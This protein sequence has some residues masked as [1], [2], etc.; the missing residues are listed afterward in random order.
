MIVPMKKVYI[1]VQEKD[2]CAAMKDLRSL[3]AVHI[4]HQALPQGADINSIKDDITLLERVIVILSAPELAGASGLR[5]LKHITEWRFTAKHIIDTSARI[6]HLGEYS[7]TL[8]SRIVEWQPWGDF[9]PASIAALE[10]K[11]I[12]VKLYQI[13][14]KELPSLGEGLIVKRVADSKGVSY[15]AV[16]SRDPVTLPY[17]EAVPPAMGLDEMRMRLTENDDIMRSL[18]DTVRKS[19]CYLD[20][21]CA[22]RG[23]F[24]RELEFHEA[25]RGMGHAG[26][27]SSLAGYIP[28]DA[29]GAL[30]EAAGRHQWALAVAD[31]SE[32]DAVPTLV[33]NP[34]W[35][36]IIRPVFQLIEITPGYRE[37]DISPVFL[38]FLALFFGMIIGDAGYGAL[39]IALTAAVQARWGKKMKDRRVFFLLYL[40]N[41]SA[42]MWGLLTGTFFGQAWFLKAGYKPLAPLLNDT[43]ALQAFCFLLGAVHLTI[44]QAWQ[45]IRK[46]PSLMALADAGWIAVIW[47]AFFLARML[48]LGDPLPAVTRWCIIAGVALVVVGTAPQR[49][50]LKMVGGGLGAVALNIMNSFTDVVSYIRLFAVG[51]AGVA[52]SDT[53]NALAAESGNLAVGALIVFA[54]HTINMVLGPMSV[55]VHGIRLNVLEFSGHAG[56]TWTGTAYKPLKD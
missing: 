33:R 18:R 5:D 17:K 50:V 29:E 19:T 2:A 25:I 48:I 54:G 26:T 40:F 7:R 11:G 37:L 41:A 16:I 32:D 24:A 4:E 6:D 21:F 46:L 53:V 43:K 8:A 55:L 39:Y 36:S 22:V 1:V 52:I 13:P 20:R 12:R 45:G 38:L 47:A 14:T 42:I 3:G 15:C 23:A 44:A 35:V 9:D 28:A 10:K 49:N 34:G 31:P 27:L 51:L 30:R 56:L